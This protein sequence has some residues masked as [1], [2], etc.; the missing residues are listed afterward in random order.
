MLHYFRPR[1]AV[2]VAGDDE[3]TKVVGT[4][5]GSDEEAPV[6]EWEGKEHVLH[7]GEVAAVG[8]DDKVGGKEH[9][10]DHSFASLLGADEEAAVVVVAF[11][12]GGEEVEE[13]G[14]AA[15]EDGE[16]EHVAFRIEAH[17]PAAY[18]ARLRVHGRESQKRNPLVCFHILLKRRGGGGGFNSLSFTPPL[19]PNAAFT[20]KPS[21]TLNSN[22]IQSPVTF[23][24]FFKN[25]HT[26]DAF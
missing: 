1:L 2:D 20:L 6:V 24:L 18:G 4:Q 7:G 13:Q 3:V 17:Q 25:K 21:I 9:R 11:G 15:D 26:L 19:S 12:G 14:A 23:I 16:E 10:H 8:G 22:H 5:Q